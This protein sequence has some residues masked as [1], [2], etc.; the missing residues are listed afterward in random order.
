MIIKPMSALGMMVFAMLFGL[1]VWVP[2][3]AENKAKEFIKKKILEA[4][5]RK[6]DHLEEQ[7]NSATSHKRADKLIKKD[8]SVPNQ[9][10]QQLKK[11]THAKIADV[12]REIADLD[13]KSRDDFA[14]GLEIITKSRIVTEDQYLH[15]IE[16]FMKRKYEELAIA[17]VR[18]LRVLSVSN[19]LVFLII[20]WNSLVSPNS[21]KN[22]LAYPTALFIGSA[23]LLFFIYIFEQDWF[24]TMIFNDYG[25]LAYMAYLFII[26]SILM[27]IILNKALGLR[28]MKRFRIGGSPE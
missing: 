7:Y 3:L 8:H 25:G 11:K 16:H 9:L 10:K 28:Y 6:I 13:S 15:Q 20:F 1:T 26:F 14:K 27:G 23:I 12:I 18:D 19:F 5:D 17:L 21:N 22:N 4:T 24:Y 2:N